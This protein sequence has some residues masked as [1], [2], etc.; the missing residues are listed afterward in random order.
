VSKSKTYRRRQHDVAA[1]TE[2][3]SRLLNVCDAQEA[4]AANPRWAARPGQEAEAGRLAAQVD[5]LA[6]RAALALGTDFYVNWK[7]RGTWQ[8][9]P[10]SPA[11]AW[12]TLFDS[13]PMF[14]AD[15][16]FA[17]CHEAIGVLDARATEAEEHEG[18]FKGKLERVTGRN[19][20]SLARK[21]SG[22]LR[23]AFVA[24]VVGIP[25]A[26]VAA[27]IAFRLGWV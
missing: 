6:G 20:R 19:R 12:R 25:A 9:Q 11:T 21:E 18:S 27:Y 23:R 2:A 16:I 4:L 24:F 8:T 26:L 13:D 14:T 10:V 5:L 7:P 3:L 17:V 15:V 22:Q 1:F